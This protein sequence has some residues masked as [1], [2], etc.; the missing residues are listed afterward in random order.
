MISCP[1]VSRTFLSGVAALVSTL[2]FAAPIAPEI[3]HLA[4]IQSKAKL[5]LSS[6]P[7]YTCGETMERSSRASGR[8]NF[9]VDDVLKLEVAEIGG[10]ELFSKAGE[11]NFNDAGLRQYANR[12]LVATGMFYH[13][14]ETIFGT[15]VAHFQFAGRKRTNGHRSLQYDLT[16]SSLFASYRLGFNNHEANCGFR[17]S[18]WADEQSLDLIRL[19][20]EATEV[21][22]EL[23]LRSAI[24]E[25]DYTRTT[26]DGK[27]YLIPSSA[28][29]TT[30][31]TN[32]DESRN[33]IRF[34]NCHK[35]GVESKLIFQ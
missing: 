14:A 17:G 24:T 8:P 26:L 19:H 11:S 16:V 32:G 12:G 22:P 21:A 4:A 18:I 6:I 29:I 25:I 2:V 1:Q 33:K 35:Y 27:T 9:R 23:R 28:Q 5:G 7:A 3:L 30:V 10:K 15:P 13:I 20:I 34:S 31:M